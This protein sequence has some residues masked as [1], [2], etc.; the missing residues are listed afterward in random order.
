MIL[1]DTH[2]LVWL[3]NE[4]DKLSTAASGAIRKASRSGGIG[5]SAISLWELAWLAKRG[6][7]KIA[8][9]I[10]A[11]LDEITSRTSIQPITAKIAA[12]ASELTPDYPLDP[13]DRLIGATA[14]VGGIPLITADERI[15]RT[16]QLDTVW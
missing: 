4:P 3:A 7:I 16:R 6:R 11:F 10:E 5:I 2:V 1:L 8:G 9:T 14:L 15:R 13:A 12:L